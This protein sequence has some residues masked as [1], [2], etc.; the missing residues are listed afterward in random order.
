M[1]VVHL[2]LDGNPTMEEARRTQDPLA[3]NHEQVRGGLEA[4][5]RAGSLKSEPA[6]EEEQERSREH[7]RRRRR[8]EEPI[9][10]RRTWA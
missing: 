7:R 9:R 1:T 5:E 6:P 10:Q 3:K 8:E 4:E 2:G